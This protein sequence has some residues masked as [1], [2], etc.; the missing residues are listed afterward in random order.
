MMKEMYIRQ[1]KERID[2]QFYIDR[3]GK[4]HKYCGPMDVSI[5]SMHYEIASAVYP[6]SDRPTDILDRLG[7]VMVGSTVY[8]CPIISKKATNRQIRT[9]EKLGLYDWLHTSHKGYLYPYK[10]VCEIIY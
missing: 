7:W 8:H 2:V 9:L 4:V 1:N 6:H 5:V 10:D 3:Y